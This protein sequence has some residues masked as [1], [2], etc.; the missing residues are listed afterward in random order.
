MRGAGLYTY[1]SHFPALS[2]NVMLLPERLLVVLAC[3]LS[4]GM[5]RPPVGNPTCDNKGTH[6]NEC[7]ALDDMFNEQDLAVPW[8]VALG[9]IVFLGM[10]TLLLRSKH[11]EQGLSLITWNLVQFLALMLCSS[12]ATDHPSMRFALGM[13]SATL[14]LSHL[15]TSQALVGPAW[16]WGLR[17][18]ALLGLLAWEVCYGPAI[19]VVRWPSTPE[20]T[21]LPC[22]YLAHLAGAI[23]PDCVL[24]VL[25]ALRFACRGMWA[26]S[27]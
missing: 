20:G 5:E 4:G 8:F 13:H 14:L 19:S 23:V 12:L 21:A 22:A 18:L 7:G 24:F 27:D 10:P 16:W 25:G 15:E 2:A 6:W 17:H 26:R 1:I 3:T 11:K 9:T